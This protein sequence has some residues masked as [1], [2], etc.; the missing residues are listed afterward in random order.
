MRLRFRQFCGEGA[1]TGKPPD[2]DG[3]DAEPCQRPVADHPAKRRPP[4]TNDI[5]AVFCSPQTLPPHF[6]GRPSR[7]GSATY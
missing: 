3:A 5:A 2:C 6:S 4:C 7:R 1:G